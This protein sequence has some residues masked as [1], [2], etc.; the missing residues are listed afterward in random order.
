MTSSSPVAIGAK[1][2]TQDPSCGWFSSECV[3]H[4]ARRVQRSTARPPTAAQSARWEP[5]GRLLPGAQERAFELISGP[6][7]ASSVR[8][9]TGAGE[10]VRPLWP[11][12]LGPTSVDGPAADRIRRSTRRRVRLDRTGSRRQIH[13][14][15]NLG[16]ARQRHAYFRHPDLEH[17]LG[18]TSAR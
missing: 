17:G 7:Y 13:E 8:P 15:G 1:D 18:G 16:H 2:N 9:R 4:F 12:S 3:R 11:A 10:T 6:R 5:S 14:R